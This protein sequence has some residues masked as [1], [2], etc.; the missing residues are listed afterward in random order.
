MLSMHGAGG[1]S[2]VGELGLHMPR[3]MGKTFK[4]LFKLKKINIIFCLVRKT[5]KQ[6]QMWY[7]ISIMLEV[8]KKYHGKKIFFYNERNGLKRN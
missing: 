3:G 2:L 7:N 6:K 8:Y 1:R 5:S 4:N